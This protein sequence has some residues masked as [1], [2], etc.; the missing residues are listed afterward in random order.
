MNCPSEGS[1]VGW[2]KIND[3]YLVKL[4]IPKDAKRSS[5]T[6]MKCRCSKAKV[7]AI[8]DLEGNNPINEVTNYAHFPLT[9]KVGKMV[10]PNGFNENRWNDCSNGIHFFI[11]KQEAINY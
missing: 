1:F 7:L 6:T 5:A 4:Q 8:T 9:Y 2:K 11:N 10:H 3:K